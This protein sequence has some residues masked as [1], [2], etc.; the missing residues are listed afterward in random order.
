[1]KGPVP[2]KYKKFLKKWQELIRKQILPAFE[3][4]SPR[5][6]MIYPPYGYAGGKW[7]TPKIEIFAVSRLFDCFF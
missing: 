2:K 6:N 7:V 1:M 5:K 3:W 4:K